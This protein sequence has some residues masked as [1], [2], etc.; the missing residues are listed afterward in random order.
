MRFFSLRYGFE[1]VRINVAY[2]MS[3]VQEPRATWTG[4]KFSFNRAE[5][6]S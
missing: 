1:N 2:L 5:N 4:Q 3:G 6:L